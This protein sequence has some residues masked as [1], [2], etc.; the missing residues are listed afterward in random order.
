MPQSLDLVTAP[1]PLVDGGVLDNAPFEPLIGEIARREVDANWRRVIGYVVANDGLATTMVG[2]GDEAEGARRV[3]R[4]WFPV[5]TSTLRMSSETSFRHGVQQLAQR[6]LDAE[7]LASGPEALLVQLLE[8]GGPNPDAVASLY[9][10]Y[11]TTRTASGILDAFLVRNRPPRPQRLT[12]PTLEEAEPDAATSWV[13]GQDFERALQT[14]DFRWGTAVADRSTRLLLRQLH[15][16]SES[17]RVD[18]DDTLHRLSQVLTAVTAMRDHLERDIADHPGTRC[19]RPSTPPLRPPTR[20]A[21]STPLCRG[22]AGLRRWPGQV[23][24]RAHPPG[25]PYSGSPHSSSHRTAAVRPT[26]SIRRDP[27]GTKRADRSR[28]GRVEQRPEFRVR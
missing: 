8:G 5:L 1:A 16:W 28:P 24:P 14:G 23:R 26:G 11:R 9:P 18:V 3:A 25:R 21:F 19:S 10:L 4:E 6:S 13:P 7:R 22:R 12:L 15:A 17:A 20:R 27:H 2:G